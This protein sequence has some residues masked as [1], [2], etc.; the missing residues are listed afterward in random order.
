MIQD[1]TVKIQIGDSV[2]TKK[3]HS[4]Y[5]YERPVCTVV[6]LQSRVDGVY[7]EV[8]DP[9]GKKN[10]WWIYEL[11]LIARPEETVISTSNNDPI[12]HQKE[13]TMT[14][15]ALTNNTR[16]LVI[17]ADLGEIYSWHG[18]YEAKEW[19]FKS[20]IPGSDCA[21]VLLSEA[22]EVCKRESVE[23]LGAQRE[24]ETGE[25]YIHVRTPDNQSYRRHFDHPTCACDSCISNRFES[26]P[27]TVLNA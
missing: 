26:I 2:R 24:E 11:E 6:G 25:I 1:N 5:G 18:S 23:I 22:V 12:N 3:A 17:D 8:V 9:E 14:I 21:T 10:R 13:A 16:V 15:Q 4:V 20:T 27:S 7:F 19:G